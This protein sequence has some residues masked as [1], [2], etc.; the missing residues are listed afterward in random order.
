M[1]CLLNKNYQRKCYDHPLFSPLRGKVYYWNKEDVNDRKIWYDK[2]QFKIEELGI[3]TKPNIMEVGNVSYSFKLDEYGVYTHTL[4][5]TTSYDN[6]Q[7]SS[8]ENYRLTLAFDSDGVLYLIGLD[9]GCTCEIEGS[10]GS[11]GV[12][13]M[14]FTETSRYPKIEVNNRHKVLLD[15]ADTIFQGLFNFELAREVDGN[16]VYSVA[17][18]RSIGGMPL[19]KDGKLDTTNNHSKTAFK[20]NGK[21]QK[22]M[23]GFIGEE[24]GTFT[25]TE[26]INGEYP[27]IKMLNKLT[28]GIE[29]NTITFTGAAWSIE[30]SN[31]PL[32]DYSGYDGDATVFS[33]DYQ[34]QTIYPSKLD[35]TVRN[36]DNG[37]VLYIN[38]DIDTFYVYDTTSINGKY[39]D[40]T[41]RAV[42]NPT[43]R[44]NITSLPQ[45]VSLINTSLNDGVYSYTIA[46]DDDTQ[47]FFDD[48]E[49]TDANGK[50][51]YQEIKYTMA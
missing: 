30:T 41:F 40:I 51:E 22:G 15:D 25:N 4:T 3:G 9:N 8:W 5:L 10:M 37:D 35:I 6:I 44:L 14:K 11:D 32:S 12:I 7:A 17:V 1:G 20:R 50:K 18:Y 46:I 39:T 23:T 38:D 47:D 26:M 13:T 48:I 43:K 28:Y 33:T 2:E 16:L 42:S 19:I 49:I 36:A 27:H 24:V 34:T 31:V 45:G 29:G 21:I